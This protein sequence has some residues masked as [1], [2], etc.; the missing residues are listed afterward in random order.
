MARVNSRRAK[1]WGA[2]WSREDYGLVTV[3]A[4]AGLTVIA[5]TVYCN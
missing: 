5:D 3:A 4:M 2:R 1:L